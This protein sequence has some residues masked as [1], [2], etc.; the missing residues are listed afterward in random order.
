MQKPLKS[1]LCLDGLQKRRVPE[2]G[3]IQPLPQGCWRRGRGKAGHVPL[4]FP[5]LGPGKRQPLEREGRSWCVSV[6]AL[7]G[8][9]G[10]AAAG[11]LAKTLCNKV[12]QLGRSLEVPG[13]VLSSG[14]P[15]R[16]HGVLLGSPVLWHGCSGAELTAPGSGRACCQGCWRGRSLRLGKS[17]VPAHG[18]AR[19]VMTVI[20]A[21]SKA[22]GFHLASA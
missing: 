18:A 3:T 12:E 14:C 22:G 6:C 17:C 10:H 21:L 13:W 16:T 7:A 1:L 19:N 5:S 15:P 8:S 9:Y 2:Q 20:P 11:S 4:L